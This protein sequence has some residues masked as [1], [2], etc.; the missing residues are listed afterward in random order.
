MVFTSAFFKLAHGTADVLSSA[1]ASKPIYARCGAEYIG[2]TRRQLE[3]HA[4]E[5]HPAWLDNTMVNINC[6]ISHNSGNDNIN[7]S[8]NNNNGLIN[9]KDEKMRQSVITRIMKNSMIKQ[10]TGGSSR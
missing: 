1:R 6:A 8:N 3:K 7:N 9:N 10:T 4:H 5:H 2:C